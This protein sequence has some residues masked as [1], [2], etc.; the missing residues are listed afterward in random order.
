[1]LEGDPKVEGRTSL[2][3]PDYESLGALQRSAARY[4]TGSLVLLD[5]D[6]A[7][8]PDQ[9]ESI[10]PGQPQPADILLDMAGTADER[11]GGWYEELQANEHTQAAISES[12]DVLQ[13][14]GNVVIVTP[15]GDVLDIGFAQ[16]AVQGLIDA[17]RPGY[18]PYSAII[19]SRMT[20]MLG[21]DF[22]GHGTM[23]TTAVLKV[24]CDTIFLTI[25]RTK[26]A[27]DQGLDKLKNE[28]NEGVGVRLQELREQGGLL[29]G[30]AP[31]GTTAKPVDGVYVIEPPSRGTRAILAD[32]KT[33]VLS[34]AIWR[35]PQSPVFDILG[36]S[37]PRTD[38]EVHT[39][40]AGM[41]DSLTARVGGKTF[42]YNRTEK[43]A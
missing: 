35:G 18:R 9:L 11:F 2:I 36:L 24:M 40:L 20:T 27:A 21:Y 31:S 22:K 10:L 12:I 15:H 25:P 13:Q 34:M 23:P 38:E 32:E 29:L 26:S 5:V 30:M 41:P 6:P 3:S 4:A 37:N 8:Y 42:K 19:A 7:T 17:A 1:M 43:T 39:L 16:A 33:R 28:S 14:G